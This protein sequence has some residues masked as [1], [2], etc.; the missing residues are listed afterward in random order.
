MLASARHR[1]KVAGVP[2]RLVLTDIDVPRRCPA[3][4]IPLVSGGDDWANSPSLDRI[5]PRMGY[6]P[7]NVIVVSRLANSIKSCATPAEILRVGRFYQ[8]LIGDRE[9]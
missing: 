9:C 7:G 8:K 4:G 1:A 6:V 3:L 2:F 5:V